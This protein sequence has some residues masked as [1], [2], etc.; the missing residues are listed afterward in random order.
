MKVRHSRTSGRLVGIAVPV[1]TATPRDA[2]HTANRVIGHRQLKDVSHLTQGSFPGDR[3]KRLHLNRV[4]E[5]E[6]I[7]KGPLKSAQLDSKTS[8]R[9][10]NPWISFSLE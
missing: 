3:I 2:E 1:Q 8:D 4:G 7:C 5:K 10:P 6:P 9:H